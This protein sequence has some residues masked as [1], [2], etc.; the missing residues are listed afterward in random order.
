MFYCK[1]TNHKEVEVCDAG[2]QIRYCFGRPGQMP[3]LTLT[4]PRASALTGQ[5]NGIGRYIHYSL[6]IPNGAVRYS[7]FFSADR[8]TEH[9][10]LDA[11][12][13]VEKDGQHLATVSCQ[14]T[15]L[16]QRLEGIDLSQ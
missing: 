11:G 13:D 15:T 2:K 16:E 9:H 6:T 5:W 1:T 4:V 7:V 8:L 14:T 10:K 3:E 12:V